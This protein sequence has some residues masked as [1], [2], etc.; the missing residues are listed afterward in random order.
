MSQILTTITDDST[1]TKEFV[2][3]TLDNLY[4][5]MMFVPYVALEYVLFIF[6]AFKL[7]V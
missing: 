7:T 5:L 3:L 1:L 4:F 6:M 2:I